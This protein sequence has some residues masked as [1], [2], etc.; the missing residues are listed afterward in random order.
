MDARAEMISK[1]RMLRSQELTGM[2][3]QLSK[4]DSL[5]EAE[6]EQLQKDANPRWQGDFAAGSLHKGYLEPDEADRLN[7]IQATWTDLRTKDA[8]FGLN[9]VRMSIA[10]I[11]AATTDDE[12]RRLL[13]SANDAWSSLDSV[14][15][16]AQRREFRQLTDSLKSR[17][18][19]RWWEFLNR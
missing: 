6:K 11:N 15:N 8:V 7:K 3:E 2:E 9:R 4:W 18:K 5:S 17:I 16:A 12:K 19:F 10:D 13:K 14:L 1:A